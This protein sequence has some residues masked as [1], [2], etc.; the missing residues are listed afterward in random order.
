MITHVNILGNMVQLV[1]KTGLTWE[2]YLM[3]FGT[4][5]DNTFHLKMNDGSLHEVSIDKFERIYQENPTL[6][7]AKLRE[8]MQVDSSVMASDNERNN[9]GETTDNLDL[10]ALCLLSEAALKEVLLWGQANN[11]L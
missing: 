5:G 9:S 8:V 4:S 1:E 3:N 11:I 6:L 10:T 7:R 2:Y